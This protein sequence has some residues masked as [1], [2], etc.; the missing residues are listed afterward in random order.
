MRFIMRTL[1]ALLCALLLP[2][3]HAASAGN[4]L[5]KFPDAH[6]LIGEM[7]AEHGFDRDEL[8]KLFRQVAF[9]PK[10]IEIMERPAESKPWFEYR[11]I[12]MTEKRIKGGVKFWE[13]NSELL[14]RAEKEYSVPA[15]IIV[16]IIGVE[17]FYG[18]HKGTHKVIEALSTLGFGYPK[19]SKFFRGQIKEFLLM[20]REEKR[21][22]LE[23]LGSYAGAMG[24]P[25]FIPSSFRHYA[26]DFD[27]DGRRDLW[28]NRADIIGSVA[29]Y[30]RQHRWKLGEPVTSRAILRGEGAERYAG[31]KVKLNIGLEKLRGLGVTT[32]QPL[33]EQ[34]ANL[35]A[36]QSGEQQKEYWV[37]LHNFY[38]ITR[39][40]RS[41]LYA[42]A[43]HQL[44]E[45]IRTSRAAEQRRDER[46]S[47]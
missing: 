31:K 8:E 41:P 9:Q 29:N 44:S 35:L 19:R 36:L 39:Y 32:Q 27:G 28:N 1:F 22:P 37:T 7:V 47:G 21:N 43:V 26:V 33:A 4:V 2:S 23:F 45:A 46:K 11:P 16:A 14:A 17:T 13:E 34:Q 6:T 3:A 20:T 40:N 15:H 18:R 24:M 30:F 12:F 25:Q 38:V 42:M 5:D 10:I